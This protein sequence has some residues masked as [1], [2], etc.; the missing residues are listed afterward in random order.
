MESHPHSKLSLVSLTQ[1]RQHSQDLGE[2]ALWLG[3][4]TFSGGQDGTIKDTL[5]TNFG[6]E[7]DSSQ[8][9]FGMCEALDWIKES[10]LFR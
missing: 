2:K 9:K 6:G 8:A 5:P 3:P 7:H 10:L 4:D 1:S